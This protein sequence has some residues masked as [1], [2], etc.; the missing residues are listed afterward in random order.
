MNK[1]DLASS[2]VF[3]HIRLPCVIIWCHDHSPSL[4]PSQALKGPNNAPPHLPNNNF[5][6]SKVPSHKQKLKYKPNHVM[7]YPPNQNNATSNI[8]KATDQ[9]ISVPLST[10]LA[11]KFQPSDGL[12]NQ[13]TFF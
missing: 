8:A 6:A 3:R 7:L 4:H 1:T 10:P 12:Q 11:P 5:A 2:I 9:Q 13:A